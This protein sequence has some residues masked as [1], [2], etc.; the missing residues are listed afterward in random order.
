MA[1]GGMV[2]IVALP[3]AVLLCL[4]ACS[5]VISQ[6][7][8]EYRISGQEQFQP[9]GDIDVC[10]MTYGRLLY[11]SG[12]EVTLALHHSEAEPSKGRISLWYH[13]VLSRKVD[14]AVLSNEFTIRSG[15]TVTLREVTP[16]ELFDNLVYEIPVPSDLSEF[17]LK[18]PDLKIDGS[19]YEIPEIS[20][21]KV[22]G[23]RTVKGSPLAC[24]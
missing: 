16:V 9:P 11:D 24:W 7:F 8:F 17:E 12:Q 13:E 21:R 15:S 20:F 18:V 22:R 14:A 10:G 23:E 4:A 3:V 5:Q 1:K 2:R 19:L 6:T